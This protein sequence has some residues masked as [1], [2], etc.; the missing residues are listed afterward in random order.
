MIRETEGRKENRSDQYY[1]F[2]VLANL[3][4]LISG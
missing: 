1:E 3:K 4:L 2:K